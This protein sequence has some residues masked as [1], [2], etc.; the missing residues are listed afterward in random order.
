M[1]VPTLHQ[2]AG[3]QGQA[4]PARRD[5]LD[6]LRALVAVGL[7]FFHTAV[8]WGAGE[9]PVKAASEHQAV[10]VMLAFGASWG[11][12]LLF[13]ISGMGAW[14][15]LRSRTPGTFARERLR[16]LG[17]PLLAGLLTLV[18]LQVYLGQRRAGDAGS[19]TG[20][21]ARF[22]DVRPSP[23]FPFLLEADPGGGL[24][25][26]GHLW[27]LVCLL[28]CSLVLLPGLAWLGRPAGARL[29][30]RLGRLL[31]R[32][33]GILLPVLPIAAVELALGSEVGHGGWHR[34]SYALF[35]LLGY[36]VAADPGMAEAF[37]RHWRLAAVAG[38]LAFLAAGAVH[39]LARP[40]ID[41]LTAMD[42]SSLGLRL[43][44]SL[45]GWLWVVAMLG[46]A[47]AR[48][49]RRRGAP[50]P[51]PVGRPGLARRLG[52]YANQAV[53]PFYVLHE[54]VI[55]VIAYFVL[56]WPV[57]GAVQYCLIALGSLAATLLLYDLA[58]RRTRV[59]RFLFGL[60]PGQP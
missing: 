18:P 1:T 50:A 22:W 21:L 58:V 35:F 13:V 2:P 32:P 36:L 3:R 6:L 9:F 14:Y 59:I 42:P 29:R 60:R 54:T 34:A 33:G 37:R 19:S 16:R 8:I 53:L 24:F 27:F 39:F 15:S 28:A 7:V 12:P 26:T 45:A 55:V 4:P 38:L 47:R 25:Q 41:R 49:D 57:G 40:G 23:D 10:T 5:E 11:M 31:A 52:P 44:K 30:H 20:F 51:A 17:V 48:I 43:L 46:A 56:A